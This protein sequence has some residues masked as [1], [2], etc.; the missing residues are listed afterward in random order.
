MGRTSVLDRFPDGTASIRS[1]APRVSAR[2]GPPIYGSNRSVQALSGG[3]IASRTR[4]EST[5]VASSARSTSCQLVVDSSYRPVGG[6]RMA[7]P[8]SGG[9]DVPE[10]ERMPSER[11]LSA[12]RS[13]LVLV[14]E[15][16]AG[17]AFD[18]S[19]GD[20]EAAEQGDRGDE[21]RAHVRVETG[22]RPLSLYWGKCA[23][24]PIRDCILRSTGPRN[25]SVRRGVGWSS[26][27]AGA[28]AG[29]VLESGG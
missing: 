3:R 22:R 25:R 17:P 26:G 27:R 23:R 1:R 4:R 11:V 29:G 16:R 8:G 24:G 14:H 20:E 18:E 7:V 28:V 21:F 10:G 12:S 2:Y 9:P 13:G 15:V 19:G 5:R 6:R